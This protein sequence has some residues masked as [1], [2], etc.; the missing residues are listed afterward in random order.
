MQLKDA[1]GNNVFEMKG[2]RWG[3]TLVR[4]IKVHPTKSFN[5]TTPNPPLALDFG[6]HTRHYTLQGK[7][8]NQKEFNRLKLLCAVTWYE[9]A[10]SNKMATLTIGEG[11]SVISADGVI[12]GMH[13]E[14]N[15]A[16][17]YIIVTIQFYETT[18]F[19]I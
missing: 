14:W 13:A 9:N 17:N 8:R 19:I 16:W 1:A 3:D 7:L 4:E 5:A 11:G 6:S 15:A 10:A 12:E 18:Y 2:W